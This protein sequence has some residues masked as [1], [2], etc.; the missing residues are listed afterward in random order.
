MLANW[1]HILACSQDIYDEAI[2]KGVRKE[3]ARFILPQSCTTEM[4]VTGNFQAWLDFI[5]RRTDEHAQW[6]V[7]EVA[8]EIQRL[9]RGVAPNVFG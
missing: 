9:L 4:Y 1:G 8:L 3:D 5:A 2:R 7:R 6:E